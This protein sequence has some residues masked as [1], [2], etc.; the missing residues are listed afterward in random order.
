MTAEAQQKLRQ[1]LGH[2]CRSPLAVVMGQVELIRLRAG[3]DLDPH[4]SESLDSIERAV[5]RVLSGLHEARALVP[6]EE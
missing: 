1:L 5:N 3:A 2:D 4:T 6:D